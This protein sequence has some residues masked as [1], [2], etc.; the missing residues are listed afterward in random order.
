MNLLFKLW[1][2]CGKILSLKE[3]TFYENE[4]KEAS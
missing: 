3:L 2:K 4:K 1:G